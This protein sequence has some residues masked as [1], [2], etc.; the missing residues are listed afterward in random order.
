MATG[1]G[2]PYHTGMLGDDAERID[3]LERQVQYLLGLLG[4]DPETAAAGY[5]APGTGPPPSASPEIIS[6]VQAGKPIQAIKVYRDMTGVSLKEA[7][8]V[9]DG[10]RVG[11]KHARRR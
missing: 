11:L 1:S 3:R 6:L 7:K 5:P 4:I 8:D 2:A 10:L 9:I